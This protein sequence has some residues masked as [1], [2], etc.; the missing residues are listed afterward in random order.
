M[1]IRRTF[2][3]HSTFVTL[4][5]VKKKA[6]RRKKKNIEVNVFHKEFFGLSFYKCV[7]IIACYTHADRY[8]YI[9]NDSY[10]ANI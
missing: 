8:R 2:F 10:D 4:S 1:P 9:P 3:E 7:L 5:K 6:R